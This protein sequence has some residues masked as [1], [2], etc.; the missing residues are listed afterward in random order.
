MATYTYYIDQVSGN[1]ST[2]S[3]TRLAPWKT[4]GKCIESNSALVANDTVNIVNTSS[5]QPETAV[6]DR[7]Y[8]LDANHRVNVVVTSE[9]VRLKVNRNAGGAFYY[10]ASGAA[11]LTFSIDGLDW[12]SDGVD[13]TIFNCGV[14]GSGVSLSVANASLTVT[15]ST[16]SI[17]FNQPN[18]PTTT[19]LDQTF[20]NVVTAGLFRIGGG[21]DMGDVSFTDCALPLAGATPSNNHLVTIGLINTLSFLRTTFTAAHS[22]LGTNNFLYI[23]PQRT[24][25]ISIVDC[26][27]GDS[28][29]TAHTNGSGIV[30]TAPNQTTGAAACDIIITGNGFNLTKVETAA[31]KIGSPPPDSTTRAAYYAST[32]SGGKLFGNIHVAHNSI[33]S[34]RGIS[35]GVGCDHAVYEHNYAKVTEAGHMWE[36]TANDV[37]FRY[38]YHV[39]GLCCLL[40]GDRPQCYGNVLHG[41]YDNYVVLLIG[42][43]STSG[44]G[45][46][47]GGF[48]TDNL[49][50]Q[51]G[52]ANP[53]P[54]YVLS[55]YTYNGGAQ[56]IT[57]V[58]DRNTIVQ[59]GDDAAMNINRTECATIAAARVQWAALNMPNNDSN[60]RLGGG[61]RARDGWTGTLA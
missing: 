13:V 61:L 36:T 48:V 2:G 28:G 18:S 20:S 31:I 39:G 15:N 43:S 45:W 24:T 51:E 10:A 53:N 49:L 54:A 6:N 21:G 17:L 29:C 34:K 57:T 50:I 44:W 59:L 42:E 4:L 9:N 37:V 7:I 22:E 30:I 35:L 32:F 3:G 25:L 23:V 55:D 5:A 8:M 52:N 26:I 46:T 33:T 11:A 27:I 60:S 58:F 56:T 1:D 47:I 40:F 16:G 38:N 19:G 41:V 12:T 14:S